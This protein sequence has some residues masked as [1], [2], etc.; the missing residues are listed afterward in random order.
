MEPCEL[1]L[2]C[3]LL[4]ACAGVGVTSPP[5]PRFAHVQWKKCSLDLGGERGFSGYFQLLQ[6]HNDL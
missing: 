3:S 5:P 1:Q 6:G 4:G 2:K